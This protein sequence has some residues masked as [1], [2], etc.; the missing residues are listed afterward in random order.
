LKKSSLLIIAVVFLL[1]IPGFVQA[2]TISGSS[3]RNFGG[4]C[5]SYPSITFTSDDPNSHITN[6]VIDLS[7]IN[8]WFKYGNVPL[9]GICPNNDI[10]SVTSGPL[11][12][13]TMEF[14]FTGFDSGETFC[15]NEYD[16]T[17]PNDFIPMSWAGATVTVTVDGTCELKGTFV[18]DSSG[19]QAHAD[20]SGTCGV[21]P[22]ADT[23]KDGI[24]DSQDNC[25]K[26]A[27]PDQTDS[28]GNE[29]GDACEPPVNAPEFPSRFVPVSACIA[30][31]AVAALARMQKEH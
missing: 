15:H 9:C 28:N 20:F 12:D 17:G 7:P 22:P 30:M 11:G 21:T 14:S 8:A 3:H 19:F 5:G 16:V 4:E 24:P 10:A 18:D 13:P 2:A 25:P 26:V 23:D 6:A 31:F 29:V 27:N 1:A